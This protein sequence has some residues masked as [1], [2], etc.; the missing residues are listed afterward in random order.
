M[1]AMRDCRPEDERHDPQF[2]P[3]RNRFKP[4]CQRRIYIDTATVD[5]LM[6]RIPLVAITRA[7]LISEALARRKQ[8][9]R[10]QKLLFDSLDEFREFLLNIGG[11]NPSSGIGDAVSEFVCC[12]VTCYGRRPDHPMLTRGQEAARRNAAQ[13]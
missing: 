8:E 10:N 11:A 2:E 12:F 4:L 5:D 9:R 3:L 13:R 7:P 6:A 1:E